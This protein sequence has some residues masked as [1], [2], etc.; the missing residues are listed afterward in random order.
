MRFTTIFVMPNEEFLK[1]GMFEED[2]S[3]EAIEA[4]LNLVDYKELT[5]KEN[6]KEGI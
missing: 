3:D 5:S 4:L 2:D 1:P 6:G